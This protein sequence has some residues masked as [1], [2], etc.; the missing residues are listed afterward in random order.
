[1][2]K[3]IYVTPE[4]VTYSIPTGFLCSS[5]E[6][7]LNNSTATFHGLSNEFS[8]GILEDDTQSGGGLWDENNEY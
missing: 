2:K 7:G 6:V 4:M 1:M 3:K 8:G 5:G